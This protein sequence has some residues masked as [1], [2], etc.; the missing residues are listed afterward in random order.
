LLAALNRLVVEK[1]SLRPDDLLVMI[2]E[3][4]GENISFG[5]GLAVPCCDAPPSC[6]HGR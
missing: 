3:L 1:V 6:S 5:Y 4:P 2:Y